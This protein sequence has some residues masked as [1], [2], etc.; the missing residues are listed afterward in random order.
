MNQMPMMQEMRRLH[1]AGE[2]KD[3]PAQYF[4][5]T[6]PLEE[7]FDTESDPHELNNLADDDRYRNDLLRMRIECERWMRSTGDVGLVPE[8]IF[9]ELKRPGD[10]YEETDAPRIVET[11]VPQQPDQRRITLQAITPDSSLQFSRLPST[12]YVPKKG[13][14]APPIDW[15]LYVEP[16]QAQVGA[17]IIVHASRI[18]YKTSRQ[19]RWTV[20]KPPAIAETPAPA[21]SHWRD[22]LRQSG[23][24]DRLLTLRQCDFLPLEQRRTAYRKALDD[25]HPAM[26]Y[27]G[28]WA[29][30]RSPEMR[31]PGAIAD[32]LRLLMKND[33]DP[34]VRIAAVQALAEI[35]T[36]PADIRQLVEVVENHSVATVGLAAITAL[37]DL[38]AKAKP[39]AERLKPSPDDSEYVGRIKQAIAKRWK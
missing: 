15:E 21:R 1:A 18:G 14:P 5:P 27:W 10:V 12:V 30:T 19:V 16:F 38:D 6:K 39:F 7:L 37:Q 9:D 4:R 28:V 2:L 29:W 33:A 25:D 36:D 34:M 17:P 26:R 32:R 35:G 3:G 22:T 24:L 31:D 20:G 23:V 13:V 11:A 8:G